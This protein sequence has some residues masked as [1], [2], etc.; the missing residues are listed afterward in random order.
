MRVQRLF[1]TLFVMIKIPPLHVSLSLVLYRAPW[2]H[3]PRSHV[4]TTDIALKYRLFKELLI[5]IV[6]FIGCGFSVVPGSGGGWWL[7]THGLLL[8]VGRRSHWKSLLM[9]SCVARVRRIYD[10]D[11]WFREGNFGVV[12]W[13]FGIFQLRWFVKWRLLNNCRSPA[14]LVFMGDKV[15]IL[16]RRSTCVSGSDHFLIHQIE[17]RKHPSTDFRSWGLNHFVSTWYYFLCNKSGTFIFQNFRRDV[18]DR[19]QLEMF[20]LQK[21]GSFCQLAQNFQIYSWGNHAW[22]FF[23]SSQ[24]SKNEDNVVC[25]LKIQRCQRDQKLIRPFPLLFSLTFNIFNHT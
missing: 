2:R 10:R 18:W 15:E 23:I 6:R 11:A 8:V 7:F 13:C 20:S 24:P 12:S 25:R 21:D 3:Q 16:W 22:F 9:A 5:E 19:N 1:V 4:Q 14:T 17:Q